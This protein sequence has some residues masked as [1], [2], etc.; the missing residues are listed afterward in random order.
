MTLKC[1]SE[2]LS[3]FQLA[4]DER[5][6]CHFPELLIKTKSW[7]YSADQA[8][9]GEGQA[10]LLEAMLDLQN[11]PRFG[12][13]VICRQTGRSSVPFAVLDFFCMLPTKRFKVLIDSRCS[14]FFRNSHGFG[15]PM[16]QREHFSFTR[17]FDD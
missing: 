14:F 11:L 12:Q 1:I 16:S 6:A 10:D 9:I 3:R 2:P 13:E 7:K 15:I 17:Q 4:F 8:I 5:I